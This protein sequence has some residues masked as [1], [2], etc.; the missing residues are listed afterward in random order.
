MAG[1]RPAMTIKRIVCVD[2]VTSGLIGPEVIAGT[3]TVI[4]PHSPGI[5]LPTTDLMEQWRYAKE[6]LTPANFL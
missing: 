5:V 2:R 4:P 1:T 3:A 6:N